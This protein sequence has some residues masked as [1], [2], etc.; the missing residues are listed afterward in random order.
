MKVLK[1]TDIFRLH[2]FFTLFLLVLPAVI[3]AQFTFTTNNDSLTITDYTAQ[4]MWWLYRPRLMV[5]LLSVL[6]QMRLLSNT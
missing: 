5:I 1:L 2:C 6:G 4:M 3:Q